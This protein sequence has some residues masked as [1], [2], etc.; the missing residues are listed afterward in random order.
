MTLP[1]SESAW[2]VIPV[3]NEG[4]T[5][6]AVVAGAHR[7]GL[8]CVVVDDGSTDGSGDSAARAGAA[9]VLRH[10]RN[11][12]Y[13]AALASG[14]RAAASQPGCR[15]VISLDADGQLNPAEAVMLVRKTEDEK[16]ALAIG[17]RTRPAR[18][19][20][21][22]AAWLL[23]RLLGIRDPLCGLKVYRADLVRQYSGACGRRVGME[24]AVRIIRAGHRWVQ[25]AVSTK[26]S[27]RG[28]RYG[29]GL[30]AELNIAGAALALVPIALFD[31]KP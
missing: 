17:V 25:E 24:L 11:Q 3:F 18:I 14:L 20:E 29:K 19:S 31:H 23:G 28:S 7:A 8:Q 22:F 16:A 6:D 5:I 13:A 2:A 30:A 1:Q 21:G 4:A 9:V 12:G 27:E 26:P 10:P 15:W